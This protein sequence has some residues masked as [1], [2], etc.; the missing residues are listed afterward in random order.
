MFV[1][2]N[3]D[4]SSKLKVIFCSYIKQREFDSFSFIPPVYH[5]WNG[6]KKKKKTVSLGNLI[7]NLYTAL[8]GNHR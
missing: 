2:W 8:R 6:W 3:E 5:R 1:Y 7:A 4:G